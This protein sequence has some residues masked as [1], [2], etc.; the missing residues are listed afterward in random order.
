MAI[1]TS[2][3]TLRA[4]ADEMAQQRYGKYH[5]LRSSAWRDQYDVY[6]HRLLEFVAKAAIFSPEGG[7]PD[8][9]QNLAHRLHDWLDQQGVPRKAPAAD[10]SDYP[11]L[12]LTTRIRKLAE[13][14]RP[15][16]RKDY[17]YSAF[18]NPHLASL[19]R[20]EPD[21]I[22]GRRP[23]A[24]P[25][26]QTVA[27]YVIGEWIDSLGKECYTKEE[28]ITLMVAAYRQGQEEERWQ[29]EQM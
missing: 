23:E 14:R 17:P 20:G 5:L 2:G 3:D 11:L 19:L 15:K 24:E 10:G 22:D 26:R 28:A 29:P 16:D 9:D 12:W 27:E 25:H 7:H 21:V 4:L 1:K 13:G 8:D 18:G 6:V